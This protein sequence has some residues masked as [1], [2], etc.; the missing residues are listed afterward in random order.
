MGRGTVAAFR[1]CLVAALAGM[2]GLAAPQAAAMP[3]APQDAAP[4]AAPDG[5]AVAAAVP[6]VA[7][8]IEAY[9]ATVESLLREG[10][11]RGQAYAKLESLCATAPHRL[12]GSPGAA[13]A[14][15]WARA[16]MLGDGL[17]NV[18]LEPCL[19]PHWERGAVA[20]LRIIAPP[21]LVNE[22]LP[23]IALGGSVPTP[24]FG[25]SADVVEVKSWDELAKIGDGAKG[26]IIFFSRPMDAE[27]MDT[28]DAY[29]KAVD[30]RGRGAVEAAKAG[31]MAAIVRS[32]TTRIDD[33]PHTGAMHYEANVKKIPAAAVATR[34]AERLS[35]LL[36][37]GRTLRMMLKLECR[38]LDD[39]PSAN[40]LGEL[41]G[42]ELPDEVV[43]LGGHLDCWD[44][45][46]GAVDDGGGVCQAIEALRLIK[47]LGLQP[48][49]TIRAVAF[50]NEENGGRGARAYFTDHE[51]LLG[52]HVLAL[53]SDSGPF[54]PRAFTTDANPE[55][56]A[57]LRD[58][59]ALMRHAGIQDVVPGGGGADVDPMK[60]AGVIVMGYAPDQQRY[61]D[62]HHSD[63]DTIDQ[64]SPREI[65][66]GAACLAAMAYVVADMPDAL[67]RN[68][69]PPPA[70]ASR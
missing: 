3:F 2:A 25:L 43:V 46:Q 69:V 24:E 49:R 32:M 9:R 35:T 8:A 4:D 63:R 47:A 31:A 10:V 29:G 12:S 60:A 41:P 7:P 18:A 61:F 65:N 15:E 57:I 26:R 34:A 40:V 21:E 16:A 28:G 17:Q 11:A 6:A 44:V 54:T 59:G 36:A 23:V 30:Q 51:P 20:E 70:P 66:L 13:A 37:G 58:I 22:V 1:G 39:A 68:P 50:M 19:V 55:A 64:V 52:K 56:L 38:T 45:G 42:R 27:L 33:F 14:V 5:A 67:P 48:R 53:E 62:L